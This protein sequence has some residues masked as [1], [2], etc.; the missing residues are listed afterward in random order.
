MGKKGKKEKSRGRRGLIRFS[1][2]FL[3]TPVPR[4]E[5][6]RKKRVSSSKRPLLSKSLRCGGKGEGGRKGGKGRKA[7][8]ACRLSLSFSWRRNWGKEEKG[9]ARAR[10]PY[11]QAH[12]EKEKEE[13]RKKRGSTKRMCICH[14]SI[15]TLSFVAL[16]QVLQGKREGGKGGCYRITILPLLH[17]A[18]SLNLGGGEGK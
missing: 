11:L 2:R 3:S 9:S 16:V 13:R 6:G 17:V 8:Q 1:K 7:E 4:K 15:V 18:S 5:K 10:H 12:A 14:F